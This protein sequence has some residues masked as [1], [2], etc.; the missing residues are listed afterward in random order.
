MG[1]FWSKA[2][3]WIQ[4]CG[5]LWVDPYSMLPSVLCPRWWALL[6]KWLLYVAAPGEKRLYPEWVS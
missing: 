2:H 1:A 4:V 6:S 5:Y 3:L